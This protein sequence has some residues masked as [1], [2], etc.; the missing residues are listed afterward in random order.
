MSTIRLKVEAFAGT[1]IELRPDQVLPRDADEDGV[2]VGRHET[3]CTN[4]PTIFNPQENPE[5]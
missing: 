5:P 3:V 2:T 1:T 4:T